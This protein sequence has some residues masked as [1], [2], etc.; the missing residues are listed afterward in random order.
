RQYTGGALS[1]EEVRFEH[2]LVGDYRRYEAYFGC[3]V[4]FGQDR[5]SFSFAR[6]FLDFPG[7]QLSATL[8]PVLVEHLS[9]R[10]AAEAT[11]DSRAAQVRALIAAA[12]LDRPP[13][14]PALARALGISVATLGRQLRAE[15]CSVRDL[16]AARRMQAARRLLRDGQRSIADVAIATGYAESASFIRAFRRHFGAA[17][18]HVRRQ[19]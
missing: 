1:L 16:V 2:P 4:H 5:N 14:A 19:G 9:R 6:S 17:P 3:E 7:K 18:G 15:D 10:R 12:P 11:P 8:F 13:D